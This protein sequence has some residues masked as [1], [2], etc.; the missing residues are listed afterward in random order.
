MEHHAILYGLAASIAPSSIYDVHGLVISMAPKPYEFIWFG[1]VRGPKHNKFTWFI[2]QDR[3]Q[4]ARPFGAEPTGSGNPGRGRGALRTWAMATEGPKRPNIGPERTPG[5]QN[6]G[7]ACQA[8]DSLPRSSNA[9]FDLGIRLRTRS[10]CT[11]MAPLRMVH[12]THAAN[13]S[14]QQGPQNSSS[15]ANGSR[16]CTLTRSRSRYS[17]APG[18]SKARA[19]QKPGIPETRVY[20]NRSIPGPRLYVG[21]R[22]P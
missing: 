20:L 3:S 5:H 17:W 12:N 7:G 4:S 6:N 21:P 1:D 10:A 18:V 13:G 11:R 19:H 15:D 16:S 9:G 22:R 8:V 14:L 2:K